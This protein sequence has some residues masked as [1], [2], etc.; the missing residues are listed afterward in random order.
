M[1]N[2]L[3]GAQP[4]RILLV[5]DEEAHA[6]IIQRSF[7]REGGP[8]ELT[9]AATLADGVRAM[10]GLQFDLVI[11]DWRL[12]D[13]EGFE[14]LQRLKDKPQCPLLIMTS[15]GNEQIAVEAMRAGALDYIVK[16][17]SS[18]LAMPRIAS[19]AMQLWENVAARKL[20]EEE[21]RIAEDTF[22]IR[23]KEQKWFQL[24]VEAAPYAMIVTGIDGMII[25]A[26][27][28][29]ERLFGYRREE[30]LGQ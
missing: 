7:E 14:L 4:H 6:G 11:S 23:R 13:G 8:F 26:N 28:Q 10:A 30:L 9:I 12:P 19:R 22:R 5:E 18:L 29:T 1:N 21:L 17:E 25:V 20:A 27:S 24:V 3:N 16:S 2:T 15:H